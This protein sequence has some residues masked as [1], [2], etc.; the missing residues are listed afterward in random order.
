MPGWVASAS[1]RSLGSQASIASPVTVEILAGMPEP[2]TGPEVGAIELVTSMVSSSVTLELSVPVESGCWAKPAVAHQAALRHIPI[3]TRAIGI[4]ALSGSL[5][6]RG[7]RR[8]GNKTAE[9]LLPSG[10]Q[11]EAGTKAWA[12]DSIYT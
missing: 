1:A 2:I 8:P 11:C 4:R 12:S 5:R 10:E 3:S 6:V 7:R 9:F